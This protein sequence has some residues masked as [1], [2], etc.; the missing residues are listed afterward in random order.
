MNTREKY[1]LLLDFVI[2]NSS[3][4]AQWGNYDDDFSAGKDSRQDEVAD[5][6]RE[7]LAKLGLD[8]KLG[9]MELRTAAEFAAGEVPAED[10]GTVQQMKNEITIC[11][12]CT[13]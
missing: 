6:A 4:A 10:N 12:L 5:D 2:E 7:L 1:K 11:P 13:P 3:P 8:A 9:Y